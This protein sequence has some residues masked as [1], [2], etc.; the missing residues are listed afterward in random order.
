MPLLA[1]Y[2]KYITELLVGVAKNRKVRKTAEPVPPH[3]PADGLVMDEIP[4]ERR[5]RRRAQTAKHE[6]IIVVKKL[7]DR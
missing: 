2:A 6:T 7:A 1:G 5:A 3:L 4:D